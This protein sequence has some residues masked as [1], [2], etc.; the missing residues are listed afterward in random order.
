MQIV[1]R[2]LLAAATGLAFAGTAS[3]QPIVVKFSFVNPADSPKGKAADYWKKL[4]EEGTKGRVKIELYPNSSLYKDKEELEA[5]QLGSVQM[6][7]PT[8]GDDLRAGIEH[9]E[10]R[11]HRGVEDV[12]GGVGVGQGDLR[13]CTDNVSVSRAARAPLPP[14]TG[15]SHIQ[16]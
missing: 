2:L 10:A 8:L 5:L 1:R 4:V 3:A 9:F 15:P 16:G 7:A 6:L 11:A 13:I 12:R 14:T